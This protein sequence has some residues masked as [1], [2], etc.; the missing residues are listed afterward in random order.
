M[1]ADDGTEVCVACLSQGI[2]G[3]ISMHRGLAYCGTCFRNAK[4]AKEY[5][6]TSMKAEERV[7]QSLDRIRKAR[8]VSSSVAASDYPLSSSLRAYVPPSSG[9]R[10]SVPP[11]PAP[12]PALAP[13]PASRYMSQPHSGVGSGSGSASASGSSALMYDKRC[14]ACGEAYYTLEYHQDNLCRMRKRQ[15][16]SCLKKFTM[17]AYASH[18][19]S[20]RGRKCKFCDMM[21]MSL[22]THESMCTKNPARNTYRPRWR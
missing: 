2:D 14:P 15:C 4:E 8:E 1:T 5:V 18:V 11:G 12:A 10:V 6:L 3:T 7:Q 20:C 17:E 9:P 19:V 16:R 21:V 22:E 13:A